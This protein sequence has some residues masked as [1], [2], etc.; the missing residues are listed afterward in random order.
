MRGVWAPARLHFPMVL[1]SGRPWAWGPLTQRTLSLAALGFVRG[2]R[3]SLWWGGPSRC[4]A[5]HPPGRAERVAPGSLWCPWSAPGC[6]RCLRPSGGVVSRSQRPPPLGHRCRWCVRRAGGGVGKGGPPAPPLWGC[7]RLVVPWHA[8]CR[9]GRVSD[10]AGPSQRCGAWPAEG[11]C[12]FAQHAVPV[13]APLVASREARGSFR[14]VTGAWPVWRGKGGPLVGL[15]PRALRIALCLSLTADP[16]LPPGPGGLWD[17]VLR[18]PV[19]G[20]TNGWGRCALGEKAFSSDPR[21]CLGV[22]EPPAAAPPLRVVA[23]DA[24]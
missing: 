10:R 15:W 11:C 17:A 22:P 8:W 12:S 18:G 24:G 5:A 6:L 16:P 14:V 9:V 2:E 4:R 23:T 1:A 7:G 19:G 21:G 13:S 20:V 3:P